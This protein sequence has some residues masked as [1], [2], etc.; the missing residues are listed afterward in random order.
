[1]AD[2]KDAVETNEEKVGGIAKLKRMRAEVK[3]G[4][5]AAVVIVIFGVLFGSHA[6]CMHQWSEPTCTQP[7]VC[8]ICGAKQGKAL[9][10]DMAAATCTSPEKCRRCNF[11][12]GK[13]LGHKWV[14]A[15]CTTPEKCSRCGETRGSALGHDAGE[16][17]VTKEATCT[18]T[19]SRE[20]TCNRC[21][22]KLTEAIAKT[23]HQPGDWEVAEEPTI[24]SSGMVY[25]GKRVQKCVVCGQVLN[26]EDY[27]ITVTTSQ[28]NALGRASS[29]LDMGGFSYSSLVE[30]LEFEGFSH[31]DATFA[32]DHCGADW[33]NQAEQKAS[34]YMSFMNFSR[35]GLIEQL[36]FEGFTAEQASHGADSV[37][38]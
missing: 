23:D 30:Q 8:R 11:T 4:L 20:A 27:S 21:G 12:K 38:L 26:S 15:T 2:E 1:M 5:V 37:G 16:W 13:A 29:Y 19:G 22:Q 14:E 24:T 10:H 7:S 32:A 18:E 34:S 3:V 36:E 6:I 25:P 9:G 35:S 17:T 31:D 28:V 33:M